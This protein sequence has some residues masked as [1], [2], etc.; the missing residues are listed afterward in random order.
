M[1]IRPLVLTSILL[2]GLLTACQPA[3]APT[4]PPVTE[5]AAVIPP[6]L[7]ATAIPPTPTPAP[8]ASPSP[9]ATP[10][11]KSLREWADLRTGKGPVY[12]QDWSPDGR[13][14]VTADYDQVRV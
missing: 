3:A 14:L 12:S 4:P 5:A 6:T 2:A 7:T 8:T 13:L 10:G 1:K 9:T 11:V